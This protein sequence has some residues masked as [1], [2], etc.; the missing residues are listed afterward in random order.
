MYGDVICR[1]V[2]VSLFYGS[3]FYQLSGGVDPTA[4]S[5]RLGVL[6]F[7]IIFMVMG[8]YECMNVCMY[9]YNTQCTYVIIYI[10]AYLYI[11]FM[12]VCMYVYMYVY[13]CD[14]NCSVEVTMYVCMYVCMYVYR[15]SVIRAEDVGGQADLLPGE[16][17]ICVQC[18]HL[19]GLHLDLCGA[20]LLILCMYVYVCMYMYICS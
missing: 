1:H 4:Y 12:Y 14:F 16:E 11:Q 7:T 20:Y 10:C 15:P 18:F 2:V 5:E 13:V 19:L 3:L 9:V 6:F 17:V 8:E